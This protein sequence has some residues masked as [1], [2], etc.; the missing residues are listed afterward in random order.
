MKLSQIEYHNLPGINLPNCVLNEDLDQHIDTNQF[1]STVLAGTFPSGPPDNPTAISFVFYFFKTEINKYRRPDDILT[2][3]VKTN[4][5]E[6]VHM[7]DKYLGGMS[8][9]AENAVPLNE[10]YG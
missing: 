8:F 2:F 10:I 3:K 4:A 6:R 9:G 5:P 1:E 7:I